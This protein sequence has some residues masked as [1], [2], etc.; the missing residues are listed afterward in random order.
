MF[1]RIL[2]LFIVITVCLTTNVSTSASQS[3]SESGYSLTEKEMEQI[4]QTYLNDERLYD[5]FLADDDGIAYWQLIHKDKN[6]IWDSVIDVSSE[7]IDVKVDEKF[8]A[9]LLIALITI[10]QGDLAQQIGQ[11]SKFDHL[12]TKG[13]YIMDV[14]DIA[15][16][17]I[18]VSKYVEEIEPIIDAT[19]D[20]VKV[21]I[22]NSDEAKYWQMAI[23]DYS[24]S[25]EFLTAISQY[26]DNKTL[27]Q[28]ATE[29]INANKLLFE[30][31]IKYC[32]NS[33]GN[34]AKYS[35]EFT[36]KNFTGELLKDTEQYKNNQFVKWFA[37]E[38]LDIIGFAGPTFHMILLWGDFSFGTTNVFYRYQ[39]MKA[40]AD[41]ADT[42]VEAKN[43][44]TIPQDADPGVVFEDIQEKCELYR[45]LIATHARGEYL[46]YQLL[47]KD[48]GILSSFTE[49]ID[50][51]KEPGET[52]EAQYK[53]QVS[54]FTLYMDM[55]D[56]MF[57]VQDQD[58][59]TADQLQWLVEPT[60]DYKTVEP[61]PGPP[62]SD[63]ASNPNYGNGI[64]P[65]FQQESIFPFAEMSF[66]LYSNL[67]E[68]Y[69][70]MEANGDWQIFYMPEQ[71]DTNNLNIE[72]FDPIRY[73]NAGIAQC[74]SSIGSTLTTDKIWDVLIEVGRGGAN[75]SFVWDS[76]SQQFC[77]FGNGE[78]TSYFKKADLLELHK[79]YPVTEVRLGSLVQEIDDEY[80]GSSLEV[81]WD[82]EQINNT[83]SLYAY[84]SS[85][86]NL[87]TD[88]VYKDV[89]DFSDGLAA[90][91]LDGEKWG[92]IDEAGN[93]VTDF[94][95][96]PAWLADNEI[97]PYTDY[98]YK[99]QAFPCT[100]DTIV[101]KKDGEYGLLY[102]DGTTLI[103]F[104]ELEAMAP[105]WNNQ[106][107]AKQDGLWGLI[108]LADA[109]EKAGVSADESGE[110]TDEE[111][112]E[113]SIQRDDRSVQDENG[114]TVFTMYYDKVVL[115]GPSPICEKVNQQIEQACT[116]FFADQMAVQQ[117]DAAWQA[118]HSTGP[119][120]HTATVSVLNQQDILSIRLDIE[121]YFGG[122]HGFLGVGTLNFDLK[123]GEQLV[124]SDLFSINGSELRF[125]LQQE[126][127]DYIDQNSDMGWID[128]KEKINELLLEQYLFYIQDGMVYIQ[129]A[130]YELGASAMGC[131]SIPCK[132]V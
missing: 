84:V 97:T 67:P 127:K 62:F 94:V 64:V 29:M 109:K 15:G 5:D 69:S 130:Q 66:P 70:V 68:Y 129:F 24:R 1:K 107:W 38:G 101:V 63:I 113:I 71:V 122:M 56:L 50:S 114:D 13:D 34:L 96:E 98:W 59:L 78:G 105:S 61:I 108:D 120:I 81:N 123:T 60:W 42:L 117:Q 20:G 14:V 43:K 115:Q 87:L 75:G 37:D 86:G 33:L 6:P 27:K 49:M 58:S 2:S 119:F 55:I 19:L 40:V 44:I 116:E 54:N 132:I 23:Q 7:L 32:A 31:R 8:Y 9:D 85:S 25:S 74:Y 16:G 83:E 80:V 10:Q 30:Q 102:K 124:L 46:F 110:E 106:L 36:L 103:E 91:S 88:F 26:T 111:P 93:P 126:C 39:E 3:S 35:V 21:F 45:F 92:Y 73:D 17:F 82:W 100:D 52:Y 131:V 57:Q 53:R 125:Y 118:Y 79:P 48:G 11:Q 76:D 89:S 128:A 72:I 18:G 65:F 28:V 4:Y 90:C 41:I 112:S 95:Y 22:E 99:P 51:F 47:L 104:G 12:K 121:N 77:F